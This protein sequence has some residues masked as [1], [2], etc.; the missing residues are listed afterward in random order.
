MLTCGI[1]T[2]VPLGNLIGFV[3]TGFATG[4]TT[5]LGVGVGVTTGAVLSFSLPINCSRSRSVNIGYIVRLLT[6]SPV[7]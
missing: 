7:R 3:G 5:G 1:S 2:V 4:L 6:S